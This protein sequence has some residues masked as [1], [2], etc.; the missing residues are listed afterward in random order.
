MK[1]KIF[2]DTN[3]I[4]DNKG[5]FNTLFNSSFFDLP[6]F[7]EKHSVKNVSICL[8]EIVIK[9]RIQQRLE[10]INSAREYVNEK[11][12]S[13]KEAGHTEK[14]IKPRNDYRKNSVTKNN[15]FWYP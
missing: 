9:E 2:I 12:R 7:L 4:W 6:E 15:V 3:P 1:C 8:P 10:L 5:P 14:E 11:I 13:L